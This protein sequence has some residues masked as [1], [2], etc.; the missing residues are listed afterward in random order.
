MAA[1]V[2]NDVD[3]FEQMEQEQWELLAKSGYTEEQITALKNQKR[4][5][6]DVWMYSYMIK[7]AAWES[8]VTCTLTDC[9]LKLSV[10]QDG[11]CRRQ[12]AIKTLE[13]GLIMSKDNVQIE[14]A[15]AK[16]LFRDDQKQAASDMCSAIIEQHRRQQ[17]TDCTA[18][19]ADPCTSVSTDDISGAYYLGGWVKIHDDDHTGAYGIWQRGH[20]AVPSCPVLKRQFDKRACWDCDEE[21]VEEEV[22]VLSRLV[23]SAAAAAAG[24]FRLSELDSFSAVHLF[25][26]T[27]D[28][29]DFATS[30]LALF[31]KGTQQDRVVFRSPQPVLTADECRRVMGIVDAHHSEKLGGQWGSVRSSSVHTTDV[32]VEDISILRP[33]LRQLLRSALFPMLAA[34]FPKLADGSSTMDPT[35]GSSR[36]RVHDAFIVRYDAE[37]EAQSLSLPEH[38]DTSSMSMVVALNSESEGEYSGG[39]TWFEALDKSGM[40]SSAALISYICY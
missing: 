8:D 2:D 6:E 22:V 19:D 26:R 15:L 1:L 10:A 36:M 17:E 39:G 5:K 3:P 16:L 29:H 12:E 33:W 25:E 38:R 14:L 30:A 40:C 27:E 21:P 35:T 18:A 34:A 32:A 11:L 28:P 9:F 31:D 23:G 37:A 13:G 24:T 4:W 20:R 7:I